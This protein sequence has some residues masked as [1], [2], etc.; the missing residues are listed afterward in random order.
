MFQL[1][2]FQH[3]LGHLVET[4]QKSIGK[5]LKDMMEFETKW[6]APKDEY[7]RAFTIVIIS[8]AVVYFLLTIFRF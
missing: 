2:E 3:L 5:K 7:S 1:R 8:L 6:Y 4:K